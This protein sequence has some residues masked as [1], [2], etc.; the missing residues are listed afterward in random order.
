MVA[1]PTASPLKSDC[2]YF[3]L[4]RHGIYLSTS[5]KDDGLIELGKQQVSHHFFTFYSNKII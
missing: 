4:I 5:T 1:S 3:F 2:Q